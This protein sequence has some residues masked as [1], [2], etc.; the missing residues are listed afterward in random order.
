MVVTWHAPGNIVFMCVFFCFKNKT[1][2]YLLH[3]YS[4]MGYIG[5]Y[6]YMSFQVFFNL[7][8]R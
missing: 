2:G 8:T 7:S 3:L 1:T 6:A 5:V 4:Q